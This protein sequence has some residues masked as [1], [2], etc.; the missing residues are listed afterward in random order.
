MNHTVAVIRALQAAIR[1]TAAQAGAKKISD[2]DRDETLAAIDEIS[3][4]AFNTIAALRGL[5]SETRALVRQHSNPV[6][7]PNRQPLVEY[8]VDFS[9]SVRRDATGMWEAKAHE[10]ALAIDGALVTAVGTGHSPEEALY[11]CANTMHTMWRNG[12]P[13]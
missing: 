8:R 9:L 2:K 3:T 5:L 12:A 1:E 13:C 10:F 6:D 4:E 7:V 11:H